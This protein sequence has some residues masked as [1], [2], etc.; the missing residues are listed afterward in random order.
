MNRRDLLFIVI[1]IGCFLF[2]MLSGCSSDLVNGYGYEGYDC[3]PDGTCNYSNLT[4]CESNSEYYWKCV[5]TSQCNSWT[6]STSD[7]DINTVVPADKDIVESME[8]IEKSEEDSSSEED[9]NPVTDKYMIDWIEIPDGN[10]VSSFEMMQYEVT[11]LQYVKFLNTLR[12]NNCYDYSCVISSD[13]KW[14]LIYNPDIL[15]ETG[16]WGSWSTDAEHAN[17]PMYLVSWWGAKAFCVA[18]G[19]RL[20]TIEEWKYAARAGTTTTYYCG[21]DWNCLDD[22]AC[23]FQEETYNCCPVGQ[24]EPNDF[25]LYDM[26][27]NV[28][29][30]VDDCQYD[31]ILGTSC[32]IMGGDWYP[33]SYLPETKVT[34]SSE[35]SM[36]ANKGTLYNGFRCARD[37]E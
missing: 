24:Y 36:D 34:S 27:A 26:S 1:W 11:N 21:D 6:G 14:H 35:S 13:W 25:D 3:N 28:S 2:S 15:N 5:P 33:H 17:R 22:I 23:W 32:S 20:P 7:L 8:D 31:E 10:T 16:A 37:V 19:G 4:C 18:A 9:N 29:E 12:G 30:W